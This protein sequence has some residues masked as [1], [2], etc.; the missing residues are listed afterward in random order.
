[1]KYYER[2][3]GIRPIVTT[4]DDVDALKRMVTSLE[5]RVKFLEEKAGGGYIHP[6]KIIS[7]EEQE[8]R[9]GII[10]HLQAIKKRQQEAEKV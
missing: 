4:D 3:R 9:R 6:S 10:E 2:M 7:A 5:E 8:R 1:M